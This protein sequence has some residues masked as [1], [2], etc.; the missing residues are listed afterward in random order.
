M[1]IGKDFAKRN[2]QYVSFDEN[3]IIE[4]M[5]E[6]SKVVVKES[7]GQEKEVMRY[8][9][10]GKTFDSQSTGLAIQMD[11]CNPGD[12]I[13]IIR[14]GEGASTKYKVEVLGAQNPLNPEEKA[15]W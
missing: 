15:S 6:G 11:G 13:K 5:F 10:D 7:F 2:S 12:K 14:S 1:G 8:R 9:I 4:G 3:D